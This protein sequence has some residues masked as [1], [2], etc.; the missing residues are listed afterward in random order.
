MAKE[1]NQDGS[2]HQEAPAKAHDEG[3]GH[4][5]ADKAAAHS[6]GD[7]HDGHAHSY[8]AEDIEHVKRAVLIDKYGGLY[9]AH[10]HASWF[11]KIWHAIAPHHHHQAIIKTDVASPAFDST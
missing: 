6:K 1:S 5:K 10:I 11:S 9:D 2:H 3:H 7:H 8:S 4:G